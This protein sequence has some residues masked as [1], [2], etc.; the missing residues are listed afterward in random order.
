M[1]SEYL[2]QHSDDR[3][4]AGVLSKFT[5]NAVLVVVVCYQHILCALEVEQICANDFPWTLWDFMWSQGFLLLGW[6]VLLVNGTAFDQ[7]FDVLVNV[8]P[9]N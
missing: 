2:P 4:A 7:F 9:V 3:V 8:V 6:L 1:L 5:D